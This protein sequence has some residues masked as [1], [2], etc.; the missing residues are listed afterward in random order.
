MHFDYVTDGGR[1]RRITEFSV[2][3]WVGSGWT[4]LN[5]YEPD[6]ND[7]LDE[8]HAGVISFDEL[9]YYLQDQL[10]DE[11]LWAQADAMYDAMQEDV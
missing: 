11:Y 7:I 9:P 8:Y 5:D 1:R 2:L 10:R 4:V 6:D 3:E